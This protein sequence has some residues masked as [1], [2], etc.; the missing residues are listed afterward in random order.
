MNNLNK[1]T[2]VLGAT[3]LLVSATNSYAVQKTSTATVEVKNIITIAENAAINFGSV[4]ASVDQT[5][6]ANFASLTLNPVSGAL[7]ETA[8]P[9]GVTAP[10]ALTSLTA[11]N[12]GSYT[13]SEAASFTG[14]NLTF[15]TAVATLIASGFPGTTPSF[16]V[17][18]WTAAV[19]GGPNDGGD[20]TDNTILV[21]DFDG[22]VTFSV[23]A[24][25]NT[26]KSATSATDKYVDAVYTGDY[27]VKV[28]Y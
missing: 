19:D 15:P 3:F 24:K 14:L 9:T 23:G 26:M 28:E 21:T 27:I 6:V 10:A 13:I 20:A 8:A 5:N 17:D 25:L 18:S 12:V 2:K 22:A 4:R 11:G 7:T 1:I 16:T